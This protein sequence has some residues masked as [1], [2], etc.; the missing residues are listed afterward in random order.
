MPKF[1]Y[2]GCRYYLVHFEAAVP[3]GKKPN[4]ESLSA[5]VVNSTSDP[6]GEFE[7]SNDLFNRIHHLVRWAQRSNMMSVMTDCPH[8]ERLGWLEQDH[9]N[10]PSLRYEFDLEQL[11]TKT[12]GDMADSQT[13]N[14]L[15]P[16]TA[17]EYVPFLQHPVAITR[18]QDT[19]GRA[20]LGDSP[21]WGSAFVLVPWQQYEFDGDLA[22]FR[23]HYDAIKNYLAY[24]GSRAQDGIV[25][26]GLSDWYDI[27]P[28]PPGYSQLTPLGL[29]ATA[30]Y[31]EDASIMARVADLLGKARD[32]GEYR[33][34]AGHI[35]AAF[36]RA[37]YHPASGSYA[38]GSQCANAIPLAMGLCDPTNCPAVL[39]ALIRDV[40][41]HGQTTGDVGYRYLLRALAE[42]GR[43]DVIF[44]LL[45][46]SDK[47]GYGYQLKQGATS[48]TEAWDANPDTSQNHFMLGQ[49][50]EWFYHDLGGIRGDPERPGFRRIIVD[51]QPAGDVTWVKTSYNSI[52]G[53]IVSDWQRTNGEFLLQVTIPANTTATVFVPARPGG[54]VHEGSVLAGQSPGVKFLRSEDD[55]QVYAVES[56]VYNFRSDF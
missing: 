43:S 20:A 23:E 17:P 1:F 14:G 7:C 13:T 54:V 34:L 5:G 53:K 2:S 55:R 42:S 18:T 32:A 37:F 40:R 36:N 19:D 22:L 48:L 30:F 12:V 46:Q 27:G 45:N 4:V 21:E 33:K 9:L 24:L 56:G 26:Y 10:G 16:S 15:V 50:I 51:P 52:R 28:K 39:D 29:T 6:V 11:F 25:S 35:H 38:S 31:F 41:A 47:P 3:G 8:R 44:D 49:I